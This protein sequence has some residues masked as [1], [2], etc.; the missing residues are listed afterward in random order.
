MAGITIIAGA[1]AWA[2]RRRRFG[3]RAHRR[4]PTIAIGW[5]P[6]ID[7]GAGRAG[8]CGRLG[9]VMTKWVRRGELAAIGL[10]G[11]SVAAQAECARSRFWYG[12]GVESY[13]VQMQAIKGG[14]CEITIGQYGTQ[15]QLVENLLGVTVVRR[16]S[17]GQ[18]GGFASDHF[19]YRPDA[20]YVGHDEFSVL[21]KF[22]AN[23]GVRGATRLDFTVDVVD[24]R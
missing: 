4:C 15:R 6:S 24:R 5:P 16:P 3:W 13:A 8:R 10:L 20:G 9:G 12:P 17:H 19:A 2:D 18:A 1:R 14:G 22:I 11:L 23:G 7:G 21:I